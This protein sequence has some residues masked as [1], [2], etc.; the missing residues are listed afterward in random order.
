[1]SG[2]RVPFSAQ[3]ASSLERFEQKL[4]L[5]AIEKT[6]HEKTISWTVVKRR[7]EL[8]AEIKAGTYDPTRYFRDVER[9]H[10]VS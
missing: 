3:R 8:I 7:L 9:Q 5:K 2:K 4:D 10:D 1:M 6:R